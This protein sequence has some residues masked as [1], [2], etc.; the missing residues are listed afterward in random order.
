MEK[1]CRLSTSTRNPARSLG[2]AETELEDSHRFL[3]IGVQRE[4]WPLMGPI[5]Y[6][7]VAVP[8]SRKFMM[9]SIRRGESPNSA[10]AKSVKDLPLPR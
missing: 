9:T 2:Q 3:W 8:S 5:H 6:F 7:S 1:W 10:T 4:S